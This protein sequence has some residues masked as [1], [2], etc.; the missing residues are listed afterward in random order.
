MCFAAGLD[1][2]QFGWGTDAPLARIPFLQG[3]V[4]LQRP[5]T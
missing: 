2:V 1:A 3:E 5:V 4:R